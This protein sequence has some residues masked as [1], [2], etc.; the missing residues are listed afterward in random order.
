MHAVPVLETSVEIDA[1]LQLVWDLISDVRRMSEW[2]P[3]VTSTRWRS[4]FDAPGA[5]AQFT[6]RNQHGELAWTT[7]AEI[8]EWVPQRR[9]AFRVEENWAIWS[10]QL[11]PVAAGVR[12]TQRREAPDGVS[13]LSHELTEG[14]LGGHAV[15]TET[16][17]AGM[18]QTLEAI[19][20]AVE[21]SR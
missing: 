5:G 3:Q 18:T 19:R 20:S 2:S 8:V 14:F 9:L 7:H 12:V 16:L 13:D 15:F 21:T 1:P 4:G 11:E 6:N 17:R 10:F